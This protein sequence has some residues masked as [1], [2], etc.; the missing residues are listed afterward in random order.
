[1]PWLYDIAYLRQTWRMLPVGD[2]DF[3]TSKSSQSKIP[4]GNLSVGASIAEK[5]NRFS[6]AGQA[7]LLTPFS[8][9][10]KFTE[11]FLNAQLKI[12]FSNLTAVQKHG[13]CMNISSQL[14]MTVSCS[15]KS[16]EAITRGEGGT[17][18]DVGMEGWGGERRFTLNLAT[19][20]PTADWR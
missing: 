13:K 2:A 8:G 14:K 1:M 19:Q 10:F 12:W 3:N 7:V 15:S 18:G 20:Q 16:Y 6:A 5:A 9:T 17:F 4:A 11:L